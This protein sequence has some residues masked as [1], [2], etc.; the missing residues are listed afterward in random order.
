MTFNKE[1]NEEEGE[2][3]NLKKQII[4]RTVALK[5]TLAIYDIPFQFENT[6]SEVK[7]RL[8]IKI[9]LKKEMKSKNM[10]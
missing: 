4:F 10:K 3:N 5:C 8:R 9:K 1:K 7:D 6:M 2:E